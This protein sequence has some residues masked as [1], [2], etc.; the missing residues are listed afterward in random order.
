MTNIK[1]VGE[2]INVPLTYWE[3]LW[4]GQFDFTYRGGRWQRKIADSQVYSQVRDHSCLP[5]PFGFIKYKIKQ[6]IKR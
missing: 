5:H 6:E 1:S 3:E 2:E 4:L